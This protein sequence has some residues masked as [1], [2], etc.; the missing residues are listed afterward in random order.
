MACHAD[1]SAICQSLC[2]SLCRV[3][4]VNRDQLAAVSSWPRL[5]RCC[6]DMALLS[7]PSPPNTWFRPINIDQGFLVDQLVDLLVHNP[8]INFVDQQLSYFSYLFIHSYRFPSHFFISI[9][10]ILITF[11]LFT[12]I[13][14]TRPR[15][16]LHHHPILLSLW[17]SSLSFSSNSSSFPLSSSFSFSL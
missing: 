1:R 5:C 2:Q 7:L 12:I 14:V 9:V 8:H 4:F 13:F 11:I 3:L 16:P 10:L 17:L 6:L 15:Q